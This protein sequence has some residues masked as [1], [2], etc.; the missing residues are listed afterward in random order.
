MLEGKAERPRGPI[1]SR[2]VS[3]RASVDIDHKRTYSPV[4]IRARRVPTC[5]KFALGVVLFG[6]IAA[7]AQAADFATDFAQPSRAVQ[8]KFRWWWPNAL[9]DNAEI[10]NEVDQ[11][12]D[13]GFGGAEIADVHHPSTSTGLDPA[14]HGWG[15]QV[16]SLTRCRPR[17]ERAK[18]ARDD[19]PPAAP[20]RTG[21][22]RSRASRPTATAAIKELAYGS[23]GLS[24]GTTFSGPAPAAGASRPPAACHAAASSSTSRPPRSRPRATPPTHGLHARRARR[25]R[26]TSRSRRRHRQL[27]RARQTATGS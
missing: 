11:M 3:G 6:L 26:P 19:D 21:P 9:V 4:R 27:D 5:A 2:A 18:G 22:P 16:G 13:A 7:P 1:G 23:P 25:C 14:G 12:A 15:T 8:P 20:A 10:A 24:P 17:F